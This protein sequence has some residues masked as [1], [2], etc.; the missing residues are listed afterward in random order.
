MSKLSSPTP[1]NGADMNEEWNTHPIIEWLSI[2]KNILL[3][4]LVALVGSLIL[5]SRL[6]TWTTINAEKDFFQAETVFAQFQQTALL[7]QNR[8][9]S[10]E[11]LV[12]LNSIMQ[13][14]PE[15]KP[16]Y[17]G[18]MA[19]TLLISGQTPQ[20][21]PLIEDIAKRTQSEHLQ[22]YQNY[23]QT[24]VLMSQGR[25]ADA[26]QQA[27]TMKKTLDASND[28]TSPILYVFNLIRLAVLYQQLGQP[29]EELKAWEELQ[30]QPLRLDA[31]LIA[32][33]MLKIGQSSLNQYIDDRKKSLIR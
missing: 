23:T 7:P 4:I 25:Y 5:L 14:Y 22:H 12:L 31:V 29:Q 33:E 30:N 17:D 16:K 11:D 24:T 27:Q 15:L 8:V 1:S 10:D 9:T 20:A 19:Q 21:Q 3:W 26:L 32:S 28:G 6:V 2:H 18:A 13:S